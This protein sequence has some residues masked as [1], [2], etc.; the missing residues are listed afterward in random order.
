MASIAWKARGQKS[1]SA[2]QRKN[3]RRRRRRSKR[4]RPRAQRP[5]ALPGRVYRIVGALFVCLAYAFTQPTWQ[6]FVVLLFAAILTTGCRTI[7]N[8]LR[9]VDLLAPGDPSSYHR[10]MSKR[11]WSI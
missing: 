2:R 6:R 11:C 5:A 9:T 7:C 1:Q 3:E 4:N 10:V 8:L